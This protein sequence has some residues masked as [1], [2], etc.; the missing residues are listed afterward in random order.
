MSFSPRTPFP[1]WQTTILPARG[2]DWNDDKLARLDAEHLKPL[3]KKRGTQRSMGRLSPKEALELALRI[4][5]R[6][7]ASAQRRRRLLS[8]ALA[9]LD[10]HAA[11]KLHAFAADLRRGY[12]VSEA[13]VR[14][15]SAGMLGRRTQPRASAPY[16]LFTTERVPSPGLRAIDM[17][18]PA[19]DP[20]WRGD[21]RGRLS[22]QAVSR[23]AEAR[24]GYEALIARVAAKRPPRGE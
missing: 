19:G 10:A 17:T 23:A 18:P 3:L 14:R 2:T 5:T 15:D 24:Q 16:R 11:A 4:I 7:P 22:A 9:Q 6:L 1:R 13:G 21:S 8:G 20:G 12:G